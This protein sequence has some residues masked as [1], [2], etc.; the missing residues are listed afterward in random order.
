MLWYN[1]IL[2]FGALIGL[3][4]L[5]MTLIQPKRRA[6]FLHRLGWTIGR[7]N[8]LCASGQGKQ[9]IWV[10]A[11]SVGEVLSAEPIVDRL[12]ARFPNQPVVFSASTHSGMNTARRLFAGKVAAL[13][14]YP[15][16]LFFSVQRIVEHIRPKVVVIVETDIW[17]NFQ[18]CMQRRG[19]PVLLVNARLSIGS[20]RGYRL[21]GR[22][23]NRVLSSFNCIG[24]Q[25]ESDAS[26]FTRI[27]A[28]RENVLVTGNVKFDQKESAVPLSGM[29]DLR[30][31]LGID[32]RRPIIVMGSTHRGEESIGLEIFKK[33]KQRFEDLLLIVA[34]RDPGR[35]GSIGRQFRAQGL[36]VHF[37]SAL[38]FNEANDQCDALV[39]DT[40]GILRRL[41]A[42]ADVAFIGG[43]LV[44]EGGHNPLEPAAFGK[45]ILFGPDMSDFTAVAEK[46]TAAGGAFCVHDALE[47]SAAMSDLL[48]DSVRCCQVGQRALGVFREN[49]GALD[50]TMDMI[51]KALEQEPTER[52]PHFS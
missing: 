5:M 33:L 27:G 24:A 20:F 11:L 4:Y 10:H 43:S 16:D 52:C 29:K 2:M 25:S 9:P 45:A 50:K 23:S 38:A 49:Q 17:P 21:L 46:L 12:R 42:L 1:L 30:V 51:I 18:M 13:F 40:I 39:V 6:T 48:S 44:A 36:A 14:Y 34:P 32:F 7:V 31:E 41:Y 22:F 35:A 19:V 8:L 28:P 37:L 15:Y 26:R 3:P 47:L